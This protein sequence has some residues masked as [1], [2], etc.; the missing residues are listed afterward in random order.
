MRT[1]HVVCKEVT[2]FIVEVRAENEDHAYDLV[3][4]D[5]NKYDIINEWVSE[6]DVRDIQEVA[7]KLT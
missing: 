4:D 1:Y 6:W 3:R 2:T 5:V 7:R